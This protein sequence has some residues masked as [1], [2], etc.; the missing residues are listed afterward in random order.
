LLGEPVS[1]VKAHQYGIVTEV[2]ADSET[3]D[4]ATQA[5]MKLAAKP[6]AAVRLA[7]MLMKKPTADAVAKQILE[8]VEQFD[9]QLRSPEAAEALKAFSEKRAPDY[10]RFS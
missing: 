6:P 3:V 4:A 1:A 2:V 8:E 9:R 10:S 5:A 7:K